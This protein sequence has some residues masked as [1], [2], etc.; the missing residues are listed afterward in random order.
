MVLR[1]KHPNGKVTEITAPEGSKI[2]VDAQ[3]RVD[4]TL[5]EGKGKTSERPR[6][7]AVVI[8]PNVP[9]P[10]PGEPLSPTALVQR[11]AAIPGLRSWTLELDRIHFLRTDRGVGR[12]VLSP[13]GR[14]L[15]ITNDASVQIRNANTGQLERVLLGRGGRITHPSF[16]P[17]GRYLAAAEGKAVSIWDTTS[18]RVLRQ[19]GLEAPGLVAA[20]SPDGSRLAVGTWAPGAAEVWEIAS[21]RKLQSFA[22]GQTHGVGTLAWSPDSNRLASGDWPGKLFLWDAATGKL[23]QELK[24]HQEGSGLTSLAWSPDGR[25]LAGGGGGGSIFLWESD[26]GRVAR[27]LRGHEGPIHTV[28]WSPN[29]KL[30]ASGGHDR[31]VQ[32]WEPAGIKPLHVLKATDP[33]ESLAW[34]SDGRAL[35]AVGFG[36]PARVGLRQ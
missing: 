15:A 23:V 16:S 33:V 3:G 9:L 5:P 26:S 36:V 10:K 2:D 34:S 20:W 30:L 8:E 27:I 13:D 29:G 25:M 19:F 24:G 21:G 31:T 11:P 6:P 18:G 1:I 22:H 12:L 28:A 14:W 17:D 35:A 7:P 4:V 32:L